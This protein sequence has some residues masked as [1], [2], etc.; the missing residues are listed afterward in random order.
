MVRPYRLR[1]VQCAVGWG[2]TCLFLTAISSSKIMHIGEQL[3]LCPYR[4]HGVQSV[5]GGE[6]DKIVRIGIQLMPGPS[7]LSGSV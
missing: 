1:G 4:L 7:R 3:R 6:A 5:C 2:A